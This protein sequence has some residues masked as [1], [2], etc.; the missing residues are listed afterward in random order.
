M[1]SMLH[2]ERGSD[3]DGS[4]EINVYIY[5]RIYTTY[6]YWVEAL[7]K[8]SKDN[9]GKRRLGRTQGNVERYMHKNKE[10]A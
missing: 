4:R 1:I 2:Y 9:G 3:G 10:Q 7:L 8:E 5:I 6:I